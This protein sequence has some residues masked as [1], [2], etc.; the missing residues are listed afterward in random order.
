[1][2]LKRAYHEGV[3]KG[4]HLNF[5]GHKG[6]LALGR[7]GKYTLFIHGDFVC[8]ANSFKEIKSKAREEFIKRYGV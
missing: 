1:M 4:Y 2:N 5:K 7:G 8:T 6:H 3:F